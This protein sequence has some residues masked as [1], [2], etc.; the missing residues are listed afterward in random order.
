[1][2]R[3]KLVGQLS[4]LL[5]AGLLGGLLTAC[6]APAAG[7]A[8]SATAPSEVQVAT[9]KPDN[10]VAVT[11]D[12]DRLIVDVVSPSGIGNAG[13]RMATGAMPPTVLM[14][15]HLRGL[16]Q[17]TLA[18]GDAVVKLS[19]PSGGGPVLQ[20]VI[21]AGQ[22]RAIGPDSPYWMAVTQAAPPDGSD[23]VLF[24]V[25]SPPAFAASPPASFTVGWIDFYR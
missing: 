9:D 6:A 19:V 22:E 18:F 5:A 10:R 13:V 21:E 15:F 2:M 23:S 1:M 25:T 17:M 3:L 14:R 8:T 12:A 7:P 24:E 16:E 20:S 11:S 4:R